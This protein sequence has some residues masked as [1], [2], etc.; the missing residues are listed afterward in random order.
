MGHLTQVYKLSYTYD[1][2][3]EIIEQLRGIG[4]GGHE[5]VVYS[6]LLASSPANATFIAKKCNLS[7]SSVYTT[8]SLLIA[9]GLVG[10]TYKNEVKQFI[11]QDY[12]ALTELVKREREEAEKK[13]RI[14]E[15]LKDNLA[16]FTRTD[17]QLPEIVFFEGQEGLK[18][19]YLSMMRKAPPHSTRYLLR[20]EFIWGTQ[21]DFAF[22]EDWH[23]R[24]ERI[25]AEKKIETKLLVNPSKIEKSKEKIYKSEKNL[26]YRFL[27]AD[28]AVQG[29]ALY[30]IGDTT[31]IM[32]MEQN[33]LVGIK[34]SNA[35]IALN[36]RAVFESLWQSG[37]GGKN[38]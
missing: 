38:G 13:V 5:A 2:M 21:W 33:N 8:L 15:A 34:I 9:K 3:H 14:V 6:T 20:D 35:H 24:V 26:A 1:N 17:T 16:A 37:K 4:L 18:R 29:F 19:I 7:R 12:S 32:S 23:H 28:H 36:F 11:A 22:E 31:A 10:T 30:I 27:P 25:K